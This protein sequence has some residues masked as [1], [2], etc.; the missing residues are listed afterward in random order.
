MKHINNEE[1]SQPNLPK[2]VVKDIKQI[3][4]VQ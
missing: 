1:I 2:S 3:E 4:S